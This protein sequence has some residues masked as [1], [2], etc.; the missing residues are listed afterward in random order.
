MKQLLHCPSQQDNA[1]DKAT[2]QEL[3]GTACLDGGRIAFVCGAREKIDKT[4]QKR[5]VQLKLDCTCR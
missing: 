3:N 2:L 5:K 4:R 1:D